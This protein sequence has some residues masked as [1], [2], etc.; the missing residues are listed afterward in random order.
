MKPSQTL[1]KKSRLPGFTRSLR[2]AHLTFC[3]FVLNGGCE[4]WAVL[5]LKIEV[6][7]GLTVSSPSRFLLSSSRDAM[8]GR[9]FSAALYDTGTLNPLLRC[10]IVAPSSWSWFSRGWISE[11]V[12]DYH[13]HSRPRILFLCCRGHSISR[14]PDMEGCD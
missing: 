14:A 9:Q 7:T 2:G 1:F 11:R 8:H 10:F 12:S 5:E 6:I 4:P 13:R 3:C